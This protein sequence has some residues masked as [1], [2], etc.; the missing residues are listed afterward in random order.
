MTWASRTLIMIASINST[1]YVRSTGQGLPRLDL[2]ALPLLDE[3]RIRHCD[4][5]SNNRP[6]SW[7]LVQRLVHHLDV[8]HRPRRAFVSPSNFGSRAR[9]AA[10]P[11]HCDDAGA[12][13]SS[14]SRRRKRRHATCT[15]WMLLRTAVPAG[16]NRRGMSARHTK[17]PV[18]ETSTAPSAA[19]RTTPTSPKVADGV[20]ACRPCVSRPSPTLEGTVG[21]RQGQVC[22]FET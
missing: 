17:A 3:R 1:G 22:R 6:G 5:V 21:I 11:R 13:P 19:R 10:C 18:P 15:L 12:R 9:R 20:A 7:R 8:V 14:G 16:S 4:D 2:P